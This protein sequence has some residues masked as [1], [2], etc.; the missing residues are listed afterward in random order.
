MILKK[1]Q[2]PDKFKNKKPKTLILSHTAQGS[3]T[4]MKVT[5]DF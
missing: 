3:L 4:G 1:S 2:N 5:F